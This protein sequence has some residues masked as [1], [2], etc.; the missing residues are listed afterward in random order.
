MKSFLGVCVP[1]LRYH[2]L[3]VRGC[4]RFKIWSFRY[5]II[6]KLIIPLLIPRSLLTDLF[7]SL[8]SLFARNDSYHV[9][10]PPPF[11]TRIVTVPSLLYVAST[12]CCSCCCCEGGDTAGVAGAGAGGLLLAGGEG[13]FG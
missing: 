6:I 3:V 12:F 7:R 11:R 2:T 8:S 4:F 9:L 1:P 5:N 10:L 13:G